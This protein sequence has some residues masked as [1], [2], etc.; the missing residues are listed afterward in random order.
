M[1]INPNTARNAKHA[2]VCCMTGGG[3]GVA[4]NTLGLIPDKYPAM[5]FDPHGEYKTL[6]GRKVYR[7]KTRMNFAKMFKKA[8]ASGKP[9]VLAYTPKV[10]GNT[11]KEQKQSLV[12]AAHW[13]GQ[14]AWAAADGNRILYT[15]FEEYGEYSEGNASDDTIIGKIWTGGRKFGLR[16]IAV[17]QRSAEVPK[18]IWGNSPVKIIGAQGY[19]N[20][21][22]RVINA[23]G[24]NI[25]DVVDLGRRNVALTM[26]AKSLD[27]DVRTMTHYLKSE[28][29]GTFDKVAAYVPPAKHL[30]KKWNRQQQTLASDN[31]YLIAN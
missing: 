28:S 8:W 21:Q 20:D 16:A 4:M 22:K 5:I 23:L 25:A 10:T 27:E 31:T 14:L 24:C 17:F 1:A 29:I 30:T 19:E 2:C 13:F 15:L 7:Y 26:F 3:K 9:F 12:S 18:T 11:A 6:H